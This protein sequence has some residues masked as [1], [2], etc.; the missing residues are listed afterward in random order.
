MSLVIYGPSLHW[1]HTSK[2]III[3][4]SGNEKDNGV[5]V[6]LDVAGAVGEA[7]WAR[8]R[9]NMININQ[10]RRNQ[11]NCELFLFWC[12]WGRPFPIKGS[13]RVASEIVLVV[14]KRP[15]GPPKLSR[16][17]GHIYLIY[18]K[19]LTPLT[20]MWILTH[21]WFYYG[22][23]FASTTSIIVLDRAKDALGC[24]SD[25]VWTQGSPLEVA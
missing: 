25:A 1:A 13:S 3:V 17:A 5:V 10:N 16:S 8:T 18:L 4:V 20:C 19:K 12:R 9:V 7:I 22:P 14:M 24:S 23:S 6:V 2:W 15:S 21:C 11:I